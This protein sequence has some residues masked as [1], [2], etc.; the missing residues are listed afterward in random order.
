MNEH[1]FK[2]HQIHTKISHV[3]RVTQ[4]A[5]PVTTWLWLDQQLDHFHPP[6]YPKKKLHLMVKSITANNCKTITNTTQLSLVKANH[7]FAR[8]KLQWRLCHCITETRSD[9][10]F[11]ETSSCLRVPFFLIFYGSSI[12]SKVK[13]KVEEIESA[14]TVY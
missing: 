8:T 10:N 13:P 7:Q 3:N 9:P 5:Q 1:H 14:S 4:M 11:V 6:F 12:K 2:Y